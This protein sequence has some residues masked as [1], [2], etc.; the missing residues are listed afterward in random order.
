MTANLSFNINIKSMK[1]DI[2][3]MKR[4]AKQCVDEVK[5]SNW[6]HHGS[7]SV[8][9]I[10]ARRKMEVKV[11]GIALPARVRLLHTNPFPNKRASG[12]YVR[13]QAANNVMGADACKH[14]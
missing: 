2:E 5:S 12:S 7:M 11:S 9:G 10:T 14:I 4:Y 8:H 13:G 1:P 6:R 3:I